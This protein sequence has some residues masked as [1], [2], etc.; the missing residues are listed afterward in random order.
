MVL[1]VTPSSM[2]RAMRACLL[3]LPEPELVVCYVMDHAGM[4]VPIEHAALMAQAGGSDPFRI[5]DG[6]D[7]ASLP[8]LA[9]LRKARF[10]AAFKIRIG[11]PHGIPKEQQSDIAMQS[12]EVSTV[13]FK[14][15]C[16]E[17]DAVRLVPESGYAP[18]SWLHRSQPGGLARLFTLPLGLCRSPA[19]RSAHERLLAAVQ[20]GISKLSHAPGAAEQRSFRLGQASLRSMPTLGNV[21][22]TRAPSTTRHCGPLCRC[23]GTGSTPARRRVPAGC[24]S[25]PGGW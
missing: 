18:A 4:P 2:N 24:W 14:L 1:A 21:S 23:A 6:A 8:A 11:N 16:E 20:R 7:P 10:L 3:G 25:R 12:G 19:E 5:P 9:R 22:P 13:L 15:M 17:V